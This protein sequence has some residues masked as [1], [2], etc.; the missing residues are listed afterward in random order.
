MFANGTRPTADNAS[1]GEAI[2]TLRDYDTPAITETLWDA[3]PNG[4]GWTNHSVIHGQYVAADP[5]LGLKGASATGSAGIDVDQDWDEGLGCLD[6]SWNLY[7]CPHSATVNY[8]V[9]PESDGPHTVTI[10]AADVI[11]RWATPITRQFK[12]DGDAPSLRIFGGLTQLDGQFTPDDSYELLVNAVDSIPG[13]TTSGTRT[14]VYSIDD[15]VVDTRTES[16]P[17]NQ[18]CDMTGMTFT[19]RPYDY[20]PGTHNVKVTAT[21]G[22]GNVGTK[23]WNVK[24]PSGLVVSPKEGAR[25]ARW[26]TLKAQSKRS[27]QTGVKWQYNTDPGVADAA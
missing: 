17:S 12:F 11:D 15:N 21:D 25:T 13:E 8:T 7:S 16:C 4:N 6:E 10:N 1:V 2:V 23:E 3:A 20:A 18:N 5:G 26:L 27:G 9:W 19:F 14:V 22:A 24:V